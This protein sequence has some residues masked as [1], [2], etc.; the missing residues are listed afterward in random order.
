MTELVIYLLVDSL[1]PKYRRIAV[2]ECVS[3]AATLLGLLE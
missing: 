2:K 3:T 1:V